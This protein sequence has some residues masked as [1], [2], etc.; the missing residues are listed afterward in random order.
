[1][2]ILT[3]AHLSQ[4]STLLHCISAMSSQHFLCIGFV[5]L[6]S[7]EEAFSHTEVPA[8]AVQVISEDTNYH[9]MSALIKLCTSVKG[10]P[11]LGIT[12]HGGGGSPTSGRA[13]HKES[14]QAE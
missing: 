10:S 9:F 14:A 4:S 7:P 5:F 8:W 13:Q 1:M 6:L 12:D 2:P 11:M 3:V